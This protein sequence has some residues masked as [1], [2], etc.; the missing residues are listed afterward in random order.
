MAIEKIS[1][2]A[3]NSNLGLIDLKISEN[4]RLNENPIPYSRIKNGIPM[5][6]IAKKYGMKNVPPPLE[7]TI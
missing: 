1:I 5:I 4:D 3:T 2:H 6:A 7:Y